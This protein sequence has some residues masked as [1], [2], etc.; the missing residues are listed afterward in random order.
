MQAAGARL[1]LSESIEYGENCYRILLVISGAYLVTIFLVLTPNPVE[2]QTML[3]TAAKSDDNGPAE[4]CE[5]KNICIDQWFAQ[6]SV[7]H[8]DTRHLRVGL[9]CPADVLVLR[10]TLLRGA[11]SQILPFVSMAVT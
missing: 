9:P 11:L 3:A 8:K 1:S 7:I 10:G 5:Q 4:L 6:I 2:A